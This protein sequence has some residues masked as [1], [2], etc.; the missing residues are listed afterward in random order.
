LVEA[1]LQEHLMTLLLTLFV[2]HLLERPLHIVVFTL[3]H[4]LLVHLPGFEGRARLNC[5]SA[6]AARQKEGNDADRMADRE[7]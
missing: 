5:R 3:P 6:S 4:V 2:T 7:M 1:L